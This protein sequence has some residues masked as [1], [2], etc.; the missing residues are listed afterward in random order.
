MPTEAISAQDALPFMKNRILLVNP[1]VI[2]SRY[3]WVRW[4]QPLD[5]LKIGN[6][7]QCEHG[8]QVK[9]FDFMLPNPQGN[10]AKRQSKMDLELPRGEPIRWQYGASWEVFDKYLE[11]LIAQSW[12]P[13]SVLITTLTS[14]W[15]QTIPL[16][17]NRIKN[18]LNRP[19]IFLYGN[20]PFH[21]TDHAT[22][23]CAN[24]DIIINSFFDLS[25]WAANPSLYAKEKVGFW[26]LDLRS[27]E[28]VKEISD[29]IERGISHFVFFNE[30]IFEDFDKKLKPILQEIARKE[31]NIQFHGI[32]GVEIKDFPFDHAHLLARAHFSELHFEPV[33][34]KNGLIDEFLYR[35]VMDAC[36]KT[37]FCQR[38]GLGWE[39]RNHYLSG[40]LWLGLLEDDID[41]LV[42][43]ALKILQLVGMVIPKPYA[44]LPASKEYN[45]LLDKR[46]YLDPEDL[47]PH[48]MPLA[49]FNKLDKA[50]YADIYRMT[51]F[52]NMKVRAHTF[53][54]LG[55]T[56][57]SRVIRESLLGQR[58][59][60]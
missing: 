17:A 57:L 39:S 34:Q 9:L 53:D 47:S 58:W 56:Y 12:I 14:F 27:P 48:R 35:Q 11:A 45:F 46:G 10:V 44:P 49:G 41:I 1:P 28:P 2:D 8:C 25:S 32:C 20:Y 33:F 37:G 54:F 13:D 31:W 59:N 26:A 55:N 29:A 18:K 3:E 23:F 24:I 51:A 22:M 4:N 42:T 21:H 43:N 60:V 40:F 36:E 52:L 5:L 38:R 16:V 19:T 50:D 30:N 7:L 6:L 15:W